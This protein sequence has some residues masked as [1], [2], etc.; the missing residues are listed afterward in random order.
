MLI[1]LLTSR[2]ID[3]V[4]AP[5]SAGM[6]APP[7]NDPAPTDRRHIIDQPVVVRYCFLAGPEDAFREPPPPP[8]EWNINMMSEAWPGR[9]HWSIKHDDEIQRTM[10][11][12]ITTPHPHM[13][14]CERSF[15]VLITRA[16]RTGSTVH[17]T[18]AHTSAAAS[19]FL[20]IDYVLISCTH[21]LRWFRRG[22][23]KFESKLFL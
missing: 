10:D 1:F 11:V 23:V 18:T 13:A 19:D 8:P 22:G 7:E 20:S 9:A 2:V 15:F 21:P 5:S 17:R 3:V 16:R 14:E 12:D 4:I 6:V